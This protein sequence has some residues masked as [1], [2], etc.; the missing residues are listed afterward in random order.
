[1]D[2]LISK[3]TFIEW[4]RIT[5][6]HSVGIVLNNTQIYDRSRLCRMYFA[7]DSC[8]HHQANP[9]RNCI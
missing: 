3:A 5:Y 6:T 7:P 8:Q 9:M 1:M 4:M 2:V